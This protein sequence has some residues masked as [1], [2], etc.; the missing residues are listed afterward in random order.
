MKRGVLFKSA[1]ISSADLFRIAAT[2]GGRGGVVPTGAE[3]VEDANA[4]IAWVRRSAEGCCW[5]ASRGGGG[6]EILTDSSKESASSSIF[7]LVVD[8]QV[9]WDGL[10]KVR[11]RK[12]LDGGVE[13]G[14][15]GRNRK[16]DKRSTD[17]A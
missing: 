4:F 10:L 15:A 11:R 1:R 16:V 12:Y 13:R 2:A 3:G 8:V 5:E 17:E 7:I 14:G 6:E 9:I